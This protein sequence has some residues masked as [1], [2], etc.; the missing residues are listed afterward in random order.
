M[1]TG[2]GAQAGVEAVRKMGKCN[3]GCACGCARQMRWTG[4]SCWCA[5]LTSLL[6]FVDWKT[7][8]GSPDHYFVFALCHHHTMLG[9]AQLG[10]AAA[11]LHDCW[12]F[13]IGKIKL[14]CFTAFYM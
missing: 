3:R 6:E 1:C 2:G 10:L 13:F 12:I 11:R 4:Q 8:C 14:V 7:E 5:G 9:A